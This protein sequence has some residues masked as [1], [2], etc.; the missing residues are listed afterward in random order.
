MLRVLVEG[1]RHEPDLASAYTEGR[2]RGE[3]GRRGLFEQWPT[4]VWH[5]GVTAPKALD[6]YAVLVN[7][8]GYDVATRERGWTPART[9]RFWHQTLVG[10]LLARP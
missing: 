1:Q 6:V 8:P 4:T 7:F 9:E 2:R 10:Q 5:D 3:V